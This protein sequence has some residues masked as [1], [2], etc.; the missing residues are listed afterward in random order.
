MIQ[1]RNRGW[2]PRAVRG[3]GGMHGPSTG[4]AARWISQALAISP[5]GAHP[6]V[7]SPLDRES[8]PIVTVPFLRIRVVL[9]PLL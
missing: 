9:S 7:Y 2:Q 5:D 1:G 8:V 6:L 3:I 4:R